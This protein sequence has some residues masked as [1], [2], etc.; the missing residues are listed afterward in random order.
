MDK[1]EIKKALIPRLKLLENGHMST[2]N[3]ATLITMY[4]SEL[5]EEWKK[6]EKSE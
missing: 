2:E 3:A 5:F 1:E 4:I 6:E